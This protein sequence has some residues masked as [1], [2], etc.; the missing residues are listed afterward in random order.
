MRIR[1]R[2]VL[3][4][5]VCGTTMLILEG[6]KN[7]PAAPAQPVVRSVPRVSQPDIPAPLPVQGDYPGVAPRQPST[8]RRTP[9]TPMQDQPVDPQ[10]TEA[11]QRRLDSRLLQQQRAASRQ[12]QTELNDE[13]RQI[14]RQ[15]QEI[16]D[17]PRIQDAPE[18]PGSSGLG[19]DAPRIQDAPGPDQG[20]Y[21]QPAPR[22]QDA[23]GP[24]QTQPTPSQPPP[25]S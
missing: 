2:M 13:V 15:Q 24:A 19:P 14:T 8:R 20:V 23:P 11:A 22:I 1:L 7:H 6:C 9:V 10:V 5:A 16:Q 3:V 4:F 12:Q 25:Q 18:P 21:G 17:E